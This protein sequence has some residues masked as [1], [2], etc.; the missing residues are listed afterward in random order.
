M[1]DELAA[2]RGVNENVSLDEIADVYLPLSRL[3][4]LHVRAAR[5]L[6][7]VAGTISAGRSSVTPM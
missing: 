3:L 7:S 5:N 1:Y 4:N 6:N 2:L